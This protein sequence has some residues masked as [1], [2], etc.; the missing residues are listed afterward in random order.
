MRNN[1]KI[2][3]RTDLDESSTANAYSQVSDKYLKMK[4]KLHA[5]Q[6]I[7]IVED[8]SDALS[9]TTNEVRL[10]QREIVGMFPKQYRSRAE[11]LLKHM[12]MSSDLSWNQRRELTKNEKPIIGTNI[13]DLIYHA[14]RSSKEAA[15][16]RSDQFMASLKESY[17]SESWLANKNRTQGSE[18][19]IKEEA[20]DWHTPFVP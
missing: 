13:I 8:R 4:E 14:I 17:V 9:T 6:Q 18:T 10:D 5:P 20:I 15:P 19:P 1:E 3:L 16:V 2:S 7:K 12:N 11:N